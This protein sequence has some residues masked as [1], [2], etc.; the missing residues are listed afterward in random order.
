MAHGDVLMQGVRT[1]F[2]IAI[3]AESADIQNTARSALLQVGAEGGRRAAAR[4]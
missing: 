4:G 3:G 2:N 1:V